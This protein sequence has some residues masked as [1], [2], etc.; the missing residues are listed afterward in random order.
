MSA[1]VKSARVQ[2]ELVFMALARSHA[3]RGEVLAALPGEGVVTTDSGPVQEVSAA[4]VAKAKRARRTF[5]QAVSTLKKGNE[6]TGGKELKV[7][8]EARISSSDP[9][10]TEARPLT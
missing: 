7:Q 2:A 4:F 5:T 1:T 9:L 6:P 10:I 3:V 8:H